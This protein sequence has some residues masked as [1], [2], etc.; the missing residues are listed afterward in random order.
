MLRESD[1]KSSHSKWVADELPM[2]AQTLH[3]EGL[4]G[5]PSWC[6]CSEA[7]CLLTKMST[8]LVLRT[9]LP[10]A[11][12]GCVFGSFLLY[13]VLEGGGLTFVTFVPGILGVGL[14]FWFFARFGYCPKCN[15]HLGKNIGKQCRHCGHEFG[16]EDVVTRRSG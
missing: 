4:K 11:V 15:K 5:V 10:F 14:L 7:G 1:G 12:V 13:K 2:V 8:F 6:V 3:F 9:L 16:R